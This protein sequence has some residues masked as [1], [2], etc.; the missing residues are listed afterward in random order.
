MIFDSK[1]LRLKSYQFWLLI[2]CMGMGS[3]GKITECSSIIAKL[4]KNVC[5]IGFEGMKGSRTP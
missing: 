1:Q 2:D 4:G 5:I 3:L